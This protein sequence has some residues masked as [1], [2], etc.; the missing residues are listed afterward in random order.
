MLWRDGQLVD[1]GLLPGRTL[2]WAGDI[3]DRGQ[4]VGYS[5]EDQ[6]NR[7]H[8][9][10]WQDGQPIDITPAGSESCAATTI[11]NRGDIGGR[12]DDRPV[13]WRNG[14]VVPLPTLTDMPAGWATDINDRGEV[15]GTLQTPGGEALPARWTNGILE[16]LPL[17]PDAL[18]GFAAAINER[19]QIVGYVHRPDFWDPVIWENGAV[20]PLAGDWGLVFGFAWGLNNRGE[21]AV[22]AFTG[23]ITLYGAHVWRDGILQRLEP[24]GSLNDINDRGVAV[25]RVFVEGTA[26]AH[27]AVWPKAS[28]RVPVHGGGR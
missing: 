21:V 24:F 13:V 22:H 10:L 14:T 20:R 17:P 7:P 4:I 27:G 11:N 23:P 2:S 18:G 28:T 25:G 12:C 3:N 16:M 6:Y 8:A 26:E 9:V 19:G 5:S 1:L 15:V